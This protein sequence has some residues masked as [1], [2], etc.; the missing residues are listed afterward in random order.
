[1]QIAVKDMFERIG[2]DVGSERWKVLDAGR[3]VD[4]V[5]EDVR[6]RVEELLKTFEG[7]VG[8]LWA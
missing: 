3:D 4:A 6:G 2:S 5:E 7:S 1:M 8:K